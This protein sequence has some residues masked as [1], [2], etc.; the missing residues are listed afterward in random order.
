[1][2]GD[3]W[4]LE[5]RWKKPISDIS[6]NAGGQGRLIGRAAER[7][8]QMEE[9]DKRLISML[10]AVERDIIERESLHEGAIMDGLGVREMT[11][12]NTSLVWSG[13]VW[14]GRG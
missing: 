7:R 9:E 12:G 4:L 8:K 3:S 13:L 1:M 10:P 2:E 5:G 14:G 11:R 6:C